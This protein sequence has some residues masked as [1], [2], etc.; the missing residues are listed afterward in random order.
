MDDVRTNLEEVRFIAGPHQLNAAS[1]QP[2]LPNKLSMYVCRY[3][4][5]IVFSHLCSRLLS[6]KALEESFFNL[7]ILQH[8]AKLPFVRFVSQNSI[9]YTK[10]LSLSPNVFSH[11]SSFS[12]SL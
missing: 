11:L 12:L 1:N 4:S 8:A 10:F 5:T 9:L 2:A 3:V 6:I 7:L